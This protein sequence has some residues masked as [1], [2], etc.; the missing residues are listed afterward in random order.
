MTYVLLGVLCSVLV[1]VLLKLAAR[2]NLDIGQAVAW[3]YVVAASLTA[4]VLPSPVSPLHHPG[5]PWLALAA[6]GVLLPTI[7]LVFGASIRHAGIVRSDT[8]QRL[9]LVI[10]LLAAFVLFGQHFDAVIGIGCALGLIA[11]TA[12]VWRNRQATEAGG[13][14]SFGYPVAVFIGSGAIDV[15]FKFVAA[16]KVPLGTALL[17]TFALAL[18]VAFAIELAR[19]ARFTARNAV[20]GAILGLLNFGNILFY[21]QAHRTLPHDPALVFASMNLGVVALSALTGFALFGERL[22]RVN[23]AGFVVAVAAIALL[24][25]G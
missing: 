22:G 14:A 13:L 25:Q 19:Q 4:M 15:L 21:L 1:S 5:M 3:N 10:S 12:M 20:G 11:V 17:V 6:L 18:V 23:T 16:A 2:F 7:F 9:S 24:T 8:A